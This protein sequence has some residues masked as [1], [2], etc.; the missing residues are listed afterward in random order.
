MLF[1][2]SPLNFNCCAHAKSPHTIYPSLISQLSPSQQKLCAQA[3]V[4]IA[5]RNLTIS[6]IK[7]KHPLW[8]VVILAF[9]KRTAIDVAS[10]DQ[11]LL[12]LYVHGSHFRSCN[13]LQ[14]LHRMCAPIGFAQKN[15][16]THKEDRASASVPCGNR[17]QNELCN[18]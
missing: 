12:K 4:F 11:L 2:Q 18:D 9:R 8:C 5:V 7:Y 13:A 16:Q 17:I 15:N 3:I 6:D 10:C 14:R 1:I